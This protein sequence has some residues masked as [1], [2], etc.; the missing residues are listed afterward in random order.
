MT[1]EEAKKIGATH[2]SISNIL[3]F[4]YYFKVIGDDVW[5]WQLNKRFA[6]TLRRYR[7]YEDIKPL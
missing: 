7:E 5:I 1:K 2:Y 6:K 3:S 4:N